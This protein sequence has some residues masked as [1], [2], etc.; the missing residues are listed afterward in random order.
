MVSWLKSPNRVVLAS[1]PKSGNTWLRFILSNL[2]LKTDIEVNFQNIE[3]LAPGVMKPWKYWFQKKHLNPP[4]FKTHSR[5]D[6]SNAYSKN[7]YIVRDPR[8]VYIS[9]YH[10][11]D[12]DKDLSYFP[13]FMVNYAFPYGRWSEHVRS[14]LDHKD[15]EKVVIVKYESL[16][17]NP[18]R[19]LDKIMKKLSLPST[20][21]ERAEAIE[22]STFNK[23]K[24]NALRTYRDGNAPFVRKG[25]SG[26]WKESYSDEAKETFCKYEDVTLLKEFGYPPF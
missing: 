21:E 14:W 23:M 24:D 26:E 2:Y 22:K 19:E 10:Y 15:D 12:G 6:E 11:L 7:I 20:K 9:Y 17:E 3:H 4:V 8:D 25:L 16:L 13:W 1:Y 18:Q 5:Y